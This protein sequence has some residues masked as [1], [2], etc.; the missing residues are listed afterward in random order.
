M[1]GVGFVGGVGEAAEGFVS[2]AVA[3]AATAFA[4]VGVGTG[5]AGSFLS[6]VDEAAGFGGS[7]FFASVGLAYVGG[8][9]SV[10][11][12]LAAGTFVEGLV[13]LAIGP[14]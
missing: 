4:V 10:G 12:V 14:V 13:G 2:V 8:T 9:G 5:P 11:L 3:E 6:V 1:A 7:T